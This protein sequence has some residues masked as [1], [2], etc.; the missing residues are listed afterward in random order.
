M[1][2]TPLIVTALVLF[3]TS[4]PFT[5]A[6]CY[7]PNGDASP[8]D[9]PCNDDTDHSTCCG[10]GYACLSNNICVPTGLEKQIPN[11]AK[12]VRGSCTDKTWRSGNCPN[13]CVNEA[14]G[15]TLDGGIGMAKCPG[16]K[17]MY[18]CMDGFPFDCVKGDN[19]LSFSGTPTAL[20]TIGFVP[21]TS[22]T[23]TP[24]P[25]TSPAS[26]SAS[27][28]S[29]STSTSPSSTPS[30]SSTSTASSSSSASSSPASSPTAEPARQSSAPL[31][32][33][34]IA[35]VA[36]GVTV[37]VIGLSAAALMLYRRRHGSKKA[38]QASSSHQQ[39]PP[40]NNDAPAY[41]HHP[42]SHVWTEDDYKK[43]YDQ[44]HVAYHQPQA[45]AVF[46]LPD[47]RPR[48]PELPARTSRL[49][50]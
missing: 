29:T 4:L 30:R 33:G 7:Y 25:S 1:T 28:S 5:S 20:T 19:V 42:H 17:D 47:G 27:P 41:G 35:G 39:Q 43:A 50:F 36:A 21:S 12:F 14:H 18:Y 9:L 13:F 38:V 8:Q 49:R 16:N 44:V 24:T 23:S 32:T 34:L 11:A 22:L 3:L 45:V 37:G 2:I 26:S 6:I 31:S 15:D 48:T 10:P 46:E 40:Y